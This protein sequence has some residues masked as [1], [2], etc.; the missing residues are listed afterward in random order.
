MNVHSQPGGPVVPASSGKREA[1]LDAALGLFAE[2]GFHGT[3]VP[4][5]ARA[6]G[7]A[8][9]TIY[10]YFDSKEA[11]V[12]VLYRH[13]KTTLMQ[14]L[15]VDFSFTAPPREQFHVIWHRL[16]GFAR[17]EPRAFAF[18]ELHHH[19]SYLDHASR[20]LEIETLAPIAAYFE[21]T[22]AAGLTKPMPPQAL[23]AILW[24]ALVGLV[25]AQGLAHL[26]L[27]DELIQQTE[28]AC[29]DAI[30]R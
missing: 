30:A 17:H 29:W 20:R 27:T 26:E 22:R 16:G 15:L 11:L 8:T 1:I 18:L 10:R 14:R 21:T 5:V 4:E 28:D 13:C 7:V 9:G 2:R 24:G 25:K 6:A 12:N 23:M 3:S 19:S